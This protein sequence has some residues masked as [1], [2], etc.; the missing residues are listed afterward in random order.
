MDLSGSTTKAFQKVIIAFLMLSYFQFGVPQHASGTGLQHDTVQKAPVLTLASV[1]EMALQSNRSLIGAEYGV[2]GRKLALVSAWSE[3]EWKLFPGAD[4]GASDLHRRIGAGFT[5][6][7]KFSAGPMASLNPRVSNT[8]YERSD[9]DV[10][11]EVGLMLT[12]PLLRGFGKAVNL[13]GVRTAEYALRT[14]NRFHYL[15][16]INI[17]LATVG[18]VYDI[19]QQRELVDF[20]QEQTERFQ[21]H[22]V[23][24]KAK[25]KVGLATPI[26]AYRAE[27]RLQD[28]R[29]S[30][31]R[32]KEALRNAGGS[33]KL[34]LA[35]PLELAVQVVA[36]LDFKSLDINLEEAIAA[37]LENRIDLKQAADDIQEAR[38][39]SRVSEN[40][41][42]PQLDL[43]ANYSRTGS[44]IRLI[45][46]FLPNEERWYVILSSSTDWSRTA[47]KAA[48]QQSLLTVKMANLN[49]WARIDSIQQEVRQ[50]YDAL[51]KAEGRMQ[52]RN[53]QIDQAR[54]KL[55]LANVKFS[56]GMA[57]NFDVIE[58]ETELQT[59]RVNWLAAKIEHIVGR[60][61]LRGA[62]GT[63]IQ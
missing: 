32:A 15:A 33:L 38:R 42:K 50:Q 16:K 29:D 25:E 36:P 52:I 7:K 9:D 26:D 61:R 49:R 13:N 12:M 5:L 37:A 22:A 27:I 60:Y 17:V 48:Y 2:E 11:G 58:A 47:E 41:L 28:A 40:N 3:F 54:G 44:D 8:Q 14:T 10:G 55:A 30:L 56:H 24:A 34:I 23:M 45:D 31:N 57:D 19:V 51:Q 18:A 6:G 43:I 62:M 4:V 53:K 63:L 20:Y 59:A 39:A 1:I 46:T 35:S 21:R